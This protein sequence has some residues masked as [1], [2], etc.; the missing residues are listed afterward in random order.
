MNATSEYPKHMATLGEGGSTAPA[1]AE[2]APAKVEEVVEVKK[3]VA[4]KPKP[5][6]KPPTKVL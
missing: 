4:A 1:Q 2:A 5:A 6:K 3:V